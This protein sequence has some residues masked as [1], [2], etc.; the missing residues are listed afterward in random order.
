MWLFF[1]LSSKQI[2]TTPQQ[3][4]SA[5]SSH[6]P[7]HFVKTCPNAKSGSLQVSIEK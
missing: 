1:I 6:N 3:A 4:V 2:I 7:H 5:A